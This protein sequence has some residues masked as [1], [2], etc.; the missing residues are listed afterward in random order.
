MNR[1]VYVESAGAVCVLGWADG[2]E[3]L[4]EPMFFKPTPYSSA[5]HPFQHT[6]LLGRRL[7]SIL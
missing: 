7:K 5:S 2:G 4:M 1:R 3:I 6:R